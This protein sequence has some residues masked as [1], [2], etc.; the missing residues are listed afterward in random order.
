MG[1]TFVVISVN[2]YYVAVNFKGNSKGKKGTIY[3]SMHI[4]TR[5]DART[6]DTRGQKELLLQAIS[7]Q[8]F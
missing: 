3:P 8:T 4:L 1:G 7:A 2:I 5:T 6:V